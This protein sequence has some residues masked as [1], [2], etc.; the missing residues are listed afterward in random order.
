MLRQGLRIFLA[1]RL[2]VEVGTIGRGFRRLLHG[3]VQLCRDVRLFK[4]FIG[5]CK[6]VLGFRD[7]EL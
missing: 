6:A 5:F 3:F 7:N 1:H 4:S 2:N